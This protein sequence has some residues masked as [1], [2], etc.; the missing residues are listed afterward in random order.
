MTAGPLSG[1]RVIEL[2][3]IGPAPFACMM[4]ADLGADVVRVDRSGT[5][6]H[7]VLHRN[8]RSIALDLKSEAG[9]AV[10]LRL[11]GGSDV[12]VEGFR[13]GVAERLGLG[14]DDVARVAPQAVYGRMTGWGQDGPWSQLPGHDIN[15]IALTGV[16][17]A[18][19]PADGDPVVPLNLVGDFG[20]GGMLLAY[21]VLA[22]V[23]SARSTGRG[24]VV[25][26]A[27]I[28]GAA[29]LMA[30]LHGYVAEDRWV[31]RRGVN[32]LDGAAPYYR[33]YAC[34]DG[35]HIAVGCIEP[36]FFATLLSDLELDHDPVFAAQNDRARWPEM[37]ARLSETFA[38]RT[39]DA[40]AEH[41]EASSAC[42]TPVLSI[43]EAPL[44]RHHV[45]RQTYAA[46]G[47]SHMPRPAPRFDGTPALDPR[48]APVV[49][50]DGHA[51][52]TELGMDGEEVR[53]HV[54]GGVVTLP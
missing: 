43:E 7:P 36:Q 52:L 37:I 15:Y 41:F 24:Q 5:A 9:R 53:R 17:H 42:V 45:A 11:V 31:D 47:E 18:I 39:R 20:G 46:L 54:E 50:S 48:P 10:A 32:H 14:P 35:R 21:G 4:L 12:V 51:L 25:D 13:P 49:G 23:V 8:R 44:H 26:A 40:W 29:A 28:D 19:G 38:S 33:T 22:A 34:A 6:L 16:L 1:V 30:M 27:M 3:G 2:G